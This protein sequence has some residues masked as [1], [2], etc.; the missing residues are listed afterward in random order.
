MSFDL[1]LA[2]VA[3]STVLLLI[4]GPTILLVLSYAL[5]KGRSVALASAAGVALGDL[6]AMTA[7]LA[8]LGALVMTSAM[9]F[10]V[11]K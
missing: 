9:L 6:T 1:W 2:F 3:A 4:P 7:S 10:S 11:L 5:S 8:G